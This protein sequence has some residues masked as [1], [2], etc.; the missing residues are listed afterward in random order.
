MFDSAAHSLASLGALAALESL[1]DSLTIFKTLFDFRQSKRITCQRQ[2]TVCPFQ[3]RAA[4]LTSNTGR[5]DTHLTQGSSARRLLVC[6]SE[7]HDLRDV[8]FSMS[9]I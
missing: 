4:V 2:C 5:R 3:A 7:R 9:T 6:Q 8:S 1:R